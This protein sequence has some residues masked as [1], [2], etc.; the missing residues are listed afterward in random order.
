MDDE[1]SGG[2]E[3][4]N[5]AACGIC[6]RWRRVVHSVDAAQFFSCACAGRECSETY[7]KLEL[8]LERLRKIAILRDM[9]DES[10][11]DG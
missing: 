1:P 8:E 3:A 9:L 4:Q 11:D 6:D 2:A 7:E 5:W 10:D